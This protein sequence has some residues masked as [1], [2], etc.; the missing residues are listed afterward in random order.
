MI[1]PRTTSVIPALHKPDLNYM[2]TNLNCNCKKRYQLNKKIK[3]KK[4]F[5]MNKVFLSTLCNIHFV[6]PVC[7][8]PQ[9]TQEVGKLG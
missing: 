9:A 3:R 6:N 5:S 7:K 2:N 4:K 1:E 8:D